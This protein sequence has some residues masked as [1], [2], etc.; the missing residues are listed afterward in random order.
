MACRSPSGISR[1]PYDFLPRSAETGHGDWTERALHINTVDQGDAVGTGSKETIEEFPGVTGG[2]AYSSGNLDKAIAEVL[3]T[4]RV[5]LHHRIPGAGAGW[6]ISQS[7][8]DHGAQGSP[9]PG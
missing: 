5:H 7:S 1:E 6:K 4:P 3:E 2:K 9:S 8:G